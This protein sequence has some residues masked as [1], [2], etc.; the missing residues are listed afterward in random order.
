M[1]YLIQKGLPP[2]KAFKIMEAVRKGKVAK[3]KEPLWGEEYKQLMIDN[4]VPDWY[5]DSC[6]KIKYMF[7]KAHAAAYVTNAFRIAW[8]KVHI[9]KAYYA[10]YMSIRADEFDSDSMLYGKEKVLAKMEEIDKQGNAAAPKDKNMYPILELVLEMNQRGINFLPVDLYK[11]DAVNFLVEE[12]GI[13]PPFAKLTGFGEVDARKLVAARDE[14]VAQGK[15][16]SS[17][18]DMTI[19]AKLGKAAVETLRLS[20]CLDGMPRSEQMDMFD[21]L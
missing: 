11:S 10:A 19:K 2:D 5:I 1:I 13:R 9:P 6:E 14:L 21:L 7:P 18:E 4:N 12:N 3:K 20:G 17:I 16:F 8:F 15:T